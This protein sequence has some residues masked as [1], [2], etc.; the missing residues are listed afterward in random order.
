MGWGNSFVCFVKNSSFISMAYLGPCQLC[1]LELFAKLVNDFW[2][3]TIFAKISSTGPAKWISK[4]RGHG[5]LKSIVGQPWW[6]DVLE[7]FKQYNFDLSDSLLMVSA[8]KVFLF[9]LFPFFLFATQKSGWWACPPA[10][11][12]VSP[13]L[14]YRRCFSVVWLRGDLHPQSS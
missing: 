2:P 11:P 9:A 1:K 8:L 5:T 7:W 14:L 13:G 6:L 10:P 3:L 12:P 4:W